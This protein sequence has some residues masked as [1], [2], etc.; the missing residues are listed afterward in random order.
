MKGASIKDVSTD[1][2]GIFAVFSGPILF[3]SSTL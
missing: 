3:L 2:A 1:R